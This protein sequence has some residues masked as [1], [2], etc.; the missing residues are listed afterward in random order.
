MRPLLLNLNLSAAC[1]CQWHQHE[2]ETASGTAVLG[3]CLF[4]ARQD[5]RAETPELGAALAWQRER[6][7]AS[8]P[9]CA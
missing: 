5:S 1:G 9:A 3:Q 4:G 7:C 8:V 2:P 6:Y